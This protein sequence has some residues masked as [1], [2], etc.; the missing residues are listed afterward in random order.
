[1]MVFRRHEELLDDYYREELARLE[2]ERVRD[3]EKK[4]TATATVQQELEQ[5]EKI[6]SLFADDD[7]Y[8]VSIIL[9]L[10][11]DIQGEPLPL[12]QVLESIQVRAK[13]CLTLIEALK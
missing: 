1:M 7:D 13:A 4:A 3:V 5:L 9:N 6:V 8:L 2:Q 10:E 12:A 11:E